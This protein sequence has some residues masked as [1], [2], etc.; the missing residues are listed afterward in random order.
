MALWMYSNQSQLNNLGHL[1]SYG[2]YE[3]LTSSQSWYIFINQ[4]LKPFYEKEQI[5]LDQFRKIELW[6]H[7]V[8]LVYT[9][10]ESGIRSLFKMYCAKG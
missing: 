1:H 5:E 2:A 9:L 8:E 6:S 3:S 10:N 7:Q 4:K